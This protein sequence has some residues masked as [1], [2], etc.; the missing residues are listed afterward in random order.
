MFKVI[1]ANDYLYIDGGGVYA[2]QGSKPDW[3]ASL[4]F[5][6]PSNFL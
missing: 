5:P 1:V 3:V 6:D 2:N 4:Y